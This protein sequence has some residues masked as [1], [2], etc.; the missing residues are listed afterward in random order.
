MPWAERNL[1]SLRA[2]FVQLAKTRLISM[3]AL[4]RRFAISRKTGYKWLRRYEAAGEA[5]LADRS[6]RPHRLRLRVPAETR[7]F[8]V[9]ERD[10]HP[11]W[12][13]RK[14]RW[15]A[16]TDR[17]PGVPACSTITT[18][19]H[20]EGLMGAGSA[21]GQRRWQRFEHPAPNSLW[22][23]DFKGPVKTTVQPAH[24][25]TMLDDHSRFNL[26]LRA[27]A[28]QQGATVQPVLVEVFRR[29]G[30]PTTLL[31]DNGSPWGDSAEQPY[32][33]LYHLDGVADPIGG[34]GQSQSPVPSPD[35]GQRRTL[36]RDAEPGGA[37]AGH[38]GRWPAAATGV[39][40]V[41]AG[42]Q[43]PAPA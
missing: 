25:L 11:A 32:T 28:N 39:R 14:L 37:A 35:V 5:G 9:A 40:S 33:T 21:P 31:V 3:T 20:R 6:R 17:L 30:L 10:R 34:A 19:L 24:P 2:E 23:M 7:G 1:M 4:C 43:S 36:P 15:R 42:V 13:A 12:G 16:Q 38:L 29:Y 27:L 26:C 22:Q 8:L 41:A 18:L